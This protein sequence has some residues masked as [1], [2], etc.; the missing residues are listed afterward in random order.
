[1]KVSHDNNIILTDG[2]PFYCPYRIT[3]QHISYTRIPEKYF[4]F[5]TK[6][7]WTTLA[8]P[9]AATGCQTT[10][11]GNTTPLKWAQD[12]DMKNAD[13]ILLT[14]KYEDGNKQEFYYPEATLEMLHPYILAVLSKTKDG[15][16]LYNN[17]ITFYAENAT[18]EY[19]NVS[20]TGSNYKMKGTFKTITDAKDIYT[21][22]EG[23]AA[24]VLGTNTVYPF[25]AYFTPITDKAND[26]EL[27]I[28]PVPGIGDDDITPDGIDE[29]E[30][31]S[32]KD[33]KVYNLNGVRV[34][35]PSKG[36]Y[37]IKGKKVIR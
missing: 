9:F 14:N 20:V 24:F 36:I 16:S 22:N 17:P 31:T 19:G 27:T 13:I 33:D 37:I 29:I 32:T 26:P 7:G 11:N 10:I 5:Y 2:Y 30:L 8:L 25:R 18:V 35:K 6:K 4:D 23:G 3:A 1:M 28:V 15:V 12:N 21:L 34:N